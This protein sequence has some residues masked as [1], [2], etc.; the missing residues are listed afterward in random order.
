MDKFIFITDSHFKK[1][2]IK[3]RTDNYPQALFKKL[4]WVLKYCKKRKIKNII[5]GGDLFDNPNVSDNIAGR[6]A[7]M[8]DHA[9][10]HLWYT[11]G[12]HDITGKNPE[13]YVNGKLHMFESYKWF[14]FIG[15]GPVEFDNT[16]LYGVDYNKED[17]E[18]ID[19]DI[20]IHTLGQYGSKTKI[21]VIHHMITGDDKSL[22]IKGKRRLISYKDIETNADVVLCGHY[23]PGMKIKKNLLLEREIKF[24]NPGSFGRTDS[25][26]DAHGYGPGLIDVK[27]G[28]DKKF[29]LKYVEIPHAKGVFKDA[30]TNKYDIDALVN[31]SKFIDTLNKF[32]ESGIAGDEVS[33]ILDALMEDVDALP[34][35]LDGDL[36]EFILDKIKE[37]K[38]ERN[39]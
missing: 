7:R 29:K 13:T 6:I 23:H 20:P 33:T 35:E 30:K 12:N 2:N 9:K 31:S 25:W 16:V 32:R 11:I 21:I 1:N 39:R 3:T 38:N 15:D 18:S 19:F 8:F 36:C 10:I 34:F 17:E 27:V 5:H 14:H 28:K 37:V 24:A 26:A 22:I 4:K